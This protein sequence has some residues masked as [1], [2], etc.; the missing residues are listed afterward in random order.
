MTSVRFIC[1]LI[2]TAIAFLASGSSAF[3]PVNQVS[4]SSITRSST[5]LMGLLDGEQ[6]RTSLTRESEP[7]EFFATWVQY[8]NQYCGHKWYFTLFYFISCYV[9]VY[10][11]LTMI[12]LFLIWSPSSALQEYR[13]NV[14]RREASYCPCRTRRNFPSFCLRNDRLIRRTRLR[15]AN[16]TCMGDQQTN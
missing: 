4:V 10:L 14:W 7:E 3:A 8:L 5:P 13:Q 11:D 12:Y 1:A 15:T 9:Y 2:F 16:A 6:E